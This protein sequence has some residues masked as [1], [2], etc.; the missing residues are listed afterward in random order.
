MGIVNLECCCQI[1]SH[2]K[3]WTKTRRIYDV[4][5]GNVGA[6]FRDGNGFPPPS[7]LLLQIVVVISP[8]AGARTRD[9]ARILRPP[10][11]RTHLNVKVGR[12]ADDVFQVLYCMLNIGRD[13]DDEFQVLY[14]MRTVL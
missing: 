3:P 5:S 2:E 14:C 4:E 12:D 10:Q 6:Y 9:A 11:P 8:L 13:A 1:K 7:T